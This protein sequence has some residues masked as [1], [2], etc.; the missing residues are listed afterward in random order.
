MLRIKIIRRR[1]NA[2]HFLLLVTAFSRRRIISILRTA[3]GSI[4]SIN[5][6]ICFYFRQNS[7][8]L[9]KY[10]LQTGETR[11][12]NLPNAGYGN[13]TPYQVAAFTDIDFAIDEEGLWA[14]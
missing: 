7:S 10:D 3:F 12:E 4:H 9:I 11:K 14:G 8:S 6:I 13:Q 2:V 1:E 5:R